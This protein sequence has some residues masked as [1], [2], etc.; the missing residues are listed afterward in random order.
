MENPHDL[1]AVG[2]FASSVASVMVENSG[3][4]FPLTRAEADRRQ[5]ILLS[6][7]KILGI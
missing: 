5:A 1:T 6:Q 2:C 4:D 7:P 3:P